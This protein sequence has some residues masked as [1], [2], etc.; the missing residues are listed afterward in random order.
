M[1]CHWSC[2]PWW[3]KISGHSEQLRP[4]GSTLLFVN[5]RHSRVKTRGASCIGGFGQNDGR[6]K[7]E[8]GIPQTLGASCI[9]GAPYIRD[10]MV[11]HFMMKISVGD[12]AFSVV[13]T[14]RRS[15]ICD[16]SKKSPN[17][18]ST[19]N[20]FHLII[21]INGVVLCKINEEI[22]YVSVFRNL[23]VRSWL[24]NRPAKL[25]WNRY[26]NM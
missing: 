12:I 4:C 26:K 9:R 13:F 23:V 1:S 7:F 17:F 16:P 21:M 2:D 8:L 6:R 25:L 20:T 15:E 3:V 22:D 14:C 19:N 11:V 10:K 5:N 18:F 24:R